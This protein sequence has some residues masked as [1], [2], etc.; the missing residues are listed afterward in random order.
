MWIDRRLTDQV[1]AAA[2]QFPALVVTG[3]RQTGKATLLRHLFPEAAFASLD[4]PW[5]PTRPMN[6]ARSSCGATGS[7]RDFKRFLR[8]CALR[9]GQLL[10]LTELAG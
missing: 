7:L 6:E 3:G 9:S 1:L 10:N 5:P 2:R 4:L 8:A